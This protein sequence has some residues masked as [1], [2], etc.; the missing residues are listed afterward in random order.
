MIAN[1]ESDAMRSLVFFLF[2][3]NFLCFITFNAVLQYFLFNY[4]EWLLAKI[5]FVTMVCHI[6]KSYSIFL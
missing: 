2:Y 1:G 5:Y 6:K 4:W 3:K